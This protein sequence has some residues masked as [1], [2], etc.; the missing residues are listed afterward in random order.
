M[1]QPAG[2]QRRARRRR[3]TGA[4]A[5]SAR[6]PSPQVSGR[7]D[8]SRESGG[9]HQ[10]GRDGLAPSGGSRSP[11]VF[12]PSLREGKNPG[13]NSPD[14][15][16]PSRSSGEE[17]GSQHRHPAARGRVTAGISPRKKKGGTAWAVAHILY[18]APSAK[19]ILNHNQL[20]AISSISYLDDSVTEVPENIKPGIFLLL[21]WCPEI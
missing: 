7:P 1:I 20:N 19:V 8:V 9:S 3:V 14:C 2:P 4:M 15:H 13:G 18:L 12:F 10:T 6:G 16:S 5:R 11:G 21:I 17:P